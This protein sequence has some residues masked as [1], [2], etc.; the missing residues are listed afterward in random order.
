MS[1]MLLPCCV[2]VISLMSF[3]TAE[4]ARC[5]LG[6][7]YRPS[8]GVCVSKTSAINA[9]IYRAGPRAQTARVSPQV[10]PEERAVSR[11]RTARA[12]PAQDDVRQTVAREP[13]L[14][15]G[16]SR[17][18]ASD[19]PQPAMSDPAPR[20]ERT[21]APAQTGRSASA[22]ASPYGAFD[23]KPIFDAAESRIVP[24]GGEPL[25]YAPQEPPQR[26][27]PVRVQSVRSIPVGPAFVSGPSPYGHLIALEPSR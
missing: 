8:R 15:H 12:E 2:A 22:Q 24:T 4:A 17:T 9:G 11:T 14:S 1:K 10:M 19:R 6:E 23:R 16:V 26:S 13:A 3:E 27:A 20:R 7:I 25:A 5:P 18:E 21:G